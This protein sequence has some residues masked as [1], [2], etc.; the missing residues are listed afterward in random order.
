MEAEAVGV[1]AAISD[2][3]GISGGRVDGDDG[4]SDD[5][6][7]AAD[8]GREEHAQPPYQRAEDELHDTGGEHEHR[9]AARPVRKASRDGKR[10]VDRVGVEDDQQP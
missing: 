1:A 5:D 10:D 2:A 9:N 4:E 6:D 3:D 7:D 8:F